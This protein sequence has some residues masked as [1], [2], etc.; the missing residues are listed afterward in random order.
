MKPFIV[1]LIVL[2]TT[3][4]SLNAGSLE[5]LP[6]QSNDLKIIENT[7]FFQNPF[8]FVNSLSNIANFALSLFA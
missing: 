8:G 6:G 1:S 4:F 7:L 5:I 2:L 3:S